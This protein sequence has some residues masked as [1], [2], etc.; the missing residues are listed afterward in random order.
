MHDGHHDNGDG[1]D[2]VCAQP[3]QHAREAGAAL[4]EEGLHRL[5]GAHPLYVQLSDGARR[6]TRRRVGVT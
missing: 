1:D 4:G 3:V 2:G 5:H 6:V